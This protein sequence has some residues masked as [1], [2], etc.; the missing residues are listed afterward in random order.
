LRNPCQ[1]PR[2]WSICSVEHDSPEDD[3]IEQIA[4]EAHDERCVEAA[5]ARADGAVNAISLYV[6]HGS[7]TFHSVHVATAGKTAWRLRRGHC[8]IWATNFPWIS[9]GLLARPRLCRPTQYRGV[10]SRTRC[11]FSLAASR[12]YGTRRAGLTPAGETYRANDPELLNWVHATEAYGFLQA[13]HTY[14]RSLCDLQ[15][16]RFYAERIL[17]TSLYGARAPTS[18]AALKMQFEAMSNRLERSDILFEFLAIMRSAPILPLPLR[19]VQPLLMGAA[20]DLTP[21]WLQAIVGLGDQSLNAWEV[22]VARQIGSFADRL[23][24]ETNPAVQPVGERDS[25]PIICMS[26]RTH[27]E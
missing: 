24:L 4:A 16:D 14:V 11:R 15:R 23:V 6:E 18:E 8:L 7:D 21:H 5:L 1:R 10:C 3:G 13:Y 17:A 20:V 25:R 9:C 12:S 19:P 2:R 27:C 22:G 26:A